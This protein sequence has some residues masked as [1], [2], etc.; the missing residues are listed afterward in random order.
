[1]STKV[2]EIEFYF[3]DVRLGQLNRPLCLRGHYPP[4][5]TLTL[6]TAKSSMHL[7]LTEAT[8]RDFLYMQCILWGEPSPSHVSFFMSIVQPCVMGVP[9][10]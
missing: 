1:M 8:Q 7:P 5:M 2:N 6:P 3:G 9:T 10:P 4:F